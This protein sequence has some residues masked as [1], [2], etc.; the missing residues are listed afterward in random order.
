VGGGGGIANKFLQGKKKKRLVLKAGCESAL[1]RASNGKR[2]GSGGNEPGKIIKIVFSLAKMG[3]KRRKIEARGLRY[4]NV[5]GGLDDRSR[6]GQWCNCMAKLGG[7]KQFFDDRKGSR[8]SDSGCKRT[9]ARPIGALWKGGSLLQGLLRARHMGRAKKI[10]ANPAE[11]YHTV[12]NEPD[13]NQKKARRRTLQEDAGF[14]PCL[15]TDQSKIPD[16]NRG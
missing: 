13:W 11:V 3:G 14:N 9:Q 6:N 16:C 8:C 1:P 15:W 10:Y 12:N 2:K 4:Q 7:K 5:K